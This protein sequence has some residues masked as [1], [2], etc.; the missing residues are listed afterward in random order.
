MHPRGGQDH[1]KAHALFL[2]LSLSIAAYLSPAEARS[3]GGR[4]GGGHVGGLRGGAVHTRLGGGFGHQLHHGIAGPAVLTPLRTPFVGLHRFNNRSFVFFNLGGFGYPSYF[5]YPHYPYYPPPQAYLMPY[6]PGSYGVDY[7]YPYADPFGAS[8]QPAPN[9]VLVYTAPPEP[10]AAQRPQPAVPTPDTL[11]PPL[12]LDDGSL[13]F[14]VSPA[15][16]KIFIDDR[17]LGKAHELANVAEITAS[18]GRHLL[19]FRLGTERT[20][21]EVV[22]SPHRITPV[23][24]ALDVPIEASATLSSES[25][26]LRLQVAPSGAAIY[27]DGAFVRAAGSTQPLSLRLPAGQHRVQIVMPGYKGYASDIT[28]PDGGEAVVTVQLARE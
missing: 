17:Y 15:E 5:Y 3:I 10:P 9:D 6:D 22:V 24:L 13:H 26:Q 11:S 12:P 21:T 8:L 20:F 27:L 28:V 18:A 14:E 16:A 4:V 2:L 25:G 23:R 1:W 19:E 7:Q